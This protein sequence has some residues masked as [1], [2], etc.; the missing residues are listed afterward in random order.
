MLVT[1]K[2]KLVAKECKYGL[3]N[4]SNRGSEVGAGNVDRNIKIS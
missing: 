3:I 4:G 2:L 1:D